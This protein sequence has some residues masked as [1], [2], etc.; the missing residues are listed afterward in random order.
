M[1]GAERQRLR[2]ARNICS[3]LL[4]S[5]RGGVRRFAVDNRWCWCDLSL[6]HEILPF[7][8]NRWIWCVCRL[9]SRSYL[10]FVDRS[11]EL[12]GSVDS[13]IRDLKRS[14]HELRVKS[15]VQIALQALRTPQV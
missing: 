9:R 10:L 14:L 4:R 6:T 2:R 7:A 5:K 8:V 1:G 11:L 12:V 15:A 3:T 13:A